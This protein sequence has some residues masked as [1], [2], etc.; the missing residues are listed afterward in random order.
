MEIVFASV[1]GYP[2]PVM[3]DEGS[4]PDGILLFN[5]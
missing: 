2:I 1:G 3:L 4:Q 5:A